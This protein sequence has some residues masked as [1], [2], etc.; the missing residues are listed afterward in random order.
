MQLQLKDTRLFVPSNFDV[1]SIVKVGEG[2]FGEVVSI[3]HAKLGSVA[4]KIFKHDLSGHVAFKELDL[5]RYFNHKR[6]CR[7]FGAYFS[8]FPTLV[9]EQCLCKHTRNFNNQACIN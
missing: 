5:A 1:T 4:N 8:E 2:S 7:F 6:L 3:V 9:M